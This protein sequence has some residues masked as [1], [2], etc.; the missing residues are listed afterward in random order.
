M[1]KKSLKKKSE[2]GQEEYSPIQYR[3]QEIGTNSFSFLAPIQRPEDTEESFKISVFH[4][5]TPMITFRVDEGLI[6]VTMTVE[7]IRKETEEILM[8]LQN[9]FV[10]HAI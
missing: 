3:L 1:A 8:R 9:V 6:I 2:L 4:R 5:V 10:F 7:A